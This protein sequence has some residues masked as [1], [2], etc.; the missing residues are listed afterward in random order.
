MKYCREEYLLWRPTS[1]R[2]P[3]RGSSPGCVRYQPAGLLG[4]C[5]SC[6]VPITGLPSTSHPTHLE[7][8]WGEDKGRLWRVTVTGPVYPGNCSH[9]PFPRDLPRNAESR[10]T[11]RC[12]AGWVS[13][14]N[15]CF[16]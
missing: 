3:S 4:G 5:S 1:K 11:G 2:V 8:A 10:L 16:H 14:I 6:R 12:V 15:A 7:Q 13:L 9:E